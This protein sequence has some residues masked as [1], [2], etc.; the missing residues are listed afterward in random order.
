[1]SVCHVLAVP[2]AVRSGHRSLGHESHVAA[3][4]HTSGPVRAVSAF[5]S[6]ATSLAPVKEMLKEIITIK[7]TR[8]KKALAHIWDSNIV[9]SEISR[10]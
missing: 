4:T 1:M 10:S 6:R 9:E 5:N 3:G 7:K 8:N 2:M